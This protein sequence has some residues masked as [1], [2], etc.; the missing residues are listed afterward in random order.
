MKWRILN[1]LDI[2][3]APEAAAALEAVGKL[4]NLAPDRQEV[5]RRLPE[6]DAYM[7]SASVRIDDEF[8]AQ[9]SR[10][11]VIGSPSTGNDHMDVP[12]IRAAGIELFDIAKEFDLINSFSA[13][14][15]LAFGLALSV[16]RHIPPAVTS[17]REGDWARERYSGFQLLDKTLG[18]VGL[19]R[20]GKISARIGNGF[21]MR[22]LATDIAD[23]S[24]PDVEMVD[25]NTLLRE[26]D[27]ILLHVHLNETTQGMIGAEQLS[28]MKNGAVLINTTRGKVINEAA[29]LEALASGCIAGAGLD[30][31]D[32]E[33]LNAAEAAEHPLIAYARE[34]DNLVITPHIGGATTESIYHARVFMARKI[35]GYLRRCDSPNQLKAT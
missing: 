15:E 7:A 10:L 25:F 3:G 19:G 11:K 30:V 27:L 12:A 35:A 2:S 24:A 31:I 13:T 4:D 26:S 28:M 23:V 8:L 6:Y 22:V 18:I 5:L 16:I 21:A 17:A 29:L 33:W 20:L 32:G 1:T 9:A 34:H 14:S